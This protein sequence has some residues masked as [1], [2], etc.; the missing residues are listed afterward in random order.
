MK[1]TRAKFMMLLGALTLTLALALGPLAPTVDAAAGR[2]RIT[3]SAIDGGG[4]GGGG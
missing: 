4:S 1:L 2:G 3:L